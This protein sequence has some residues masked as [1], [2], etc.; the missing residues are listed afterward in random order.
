[1]LQSKVMKVYRSVK[2]RM[3]SR[4]L[5]KGKLP[6]ILFVV[7]S[8]KSEHDFI[9]KYVETQKGNPNMYVVDQPLWA[10]K[11]FIKGQATDMYSGN[12]FKVGVG[13]KIVKSRVLSEN[14][15]ETALLEQGYDR[16]IDVPVEHKQ[17]FELDIDS[18]MMDIAGIS[19]TSKSK[20]IAYDRLIKNYSQRRNPMKCEILT[21]GLDDNLEIKDFFIPSLVSDS[22]KAKAGFIHLDTSVT[23]DKTGF[24]YVITNGTKVV[25]RY[26]KGGNV[27]ED[28]LDMVYKQVMSFAIQAPSDSEISF[29][30]TRQ[31]IYYL[32][33]KGFN[34]RGV[35]ADGYQS[36]DTIQQLTV[37]G[38]NA[39]TLSLDR[40]PEGY[41]TAR[42]CI[43]EERLDLLNIRN[44][45]LE[46]E[47]INVEQ[48]G[49]TGKVD[50]TS[51]GCLV[52]D[53]SLMTS[54]G[55]KRI[56]D[57]VEGIDKVYAYDIHTKEVVQVDFR[58][59]RKTKEVSEIYEITTETGEVIE[60]TD[61]HLILTQRGYVR[62]DELTEDDSIVSIAELP[63]RKIKKIVKK[64]VDVKTPVYD[65]EVPIYENFVLTN[66]LV[67]HNSKDISDSLV[68]A[69]FNASQYKRNLSEIHGASDSKLTSE[70]LSDWSGI[71]SDGLLEQVFGINS[72]S[73][74]GEGNFKGNN[75][76]IDF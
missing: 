51:D 4:Y 57:L 35:S 63:L 25:D 28:R 8:K 1:M 6:G 14:D 7:S 69:I 70:L 76:I 16:I 22:D 62:A 21:M 43:Y 17:A 31:F 71:S 24:S 64:K 34:I 67:V 38:Y 48:D 50:H 72:D 33:G 45:L 40:T 74:Y 46:T 36:R 19:C 32:R 27:I 53:S 73:L 10:V 20:F 3:E 29:E 26:E 60:C 15:D 55:N 9:E 61:N 42:T 23:G 11:G 58:N 75:D 44:T 66:G 49:I 68:G 30:K 18:A 52:A 2:R 13:N 59:L 65:I 39:R 56:I 47:L 54:N 41:V 37:A 5:K 12:C